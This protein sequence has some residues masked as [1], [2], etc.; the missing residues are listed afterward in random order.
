MI[1]GAADT[2]TDGLADPY[3]NCPRASN[4]DQADLDGDEVGDACDLMTCGD[5]VRAFSEA[6]DDGN[7]LEND[8]C[9]A[10]CQTSIGVI[11]AFFD[12]AADEGNLAGPGESGAVLLGA[13]RN[14]IAAAEA[15]VQNGAGCGSL[16]AALNRTDGVAV[17]PDF[18]V[19]DAAPELAQRLGDSPGGPGLQVRPPVWAGLRAGL[20]A[21]AATLAARARKWAAQCWQLECRS[22]A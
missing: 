15:P 19:G 11:L 17:P 20:P 1:I 13:L 2:D 18:A 5:G 14:M 16:R 7:T 6:C 10:S 8:G 3:D 12:E 21:A 9:E 22:R 4:I